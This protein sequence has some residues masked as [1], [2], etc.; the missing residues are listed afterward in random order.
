[1][2]TWHGGPNHRY[3]GEFPKAPKDSVCRLCGDRLGD[4]GVRSLAAKDRRDVV[5][6]GGKFYHRS[7]AEAVSA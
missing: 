2:S 5:K 7:C 6:R 4:R 1:M 3:S